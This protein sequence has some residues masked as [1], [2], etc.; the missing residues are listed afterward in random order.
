M[1]KTLWILAVSGAIFASCQKD[2]VDL[3]TAEGEVLV[4]FNTTLP[5]GLTTR[6]GDT[7]KGGVAENVDFASYD[8]RFIMEVYQPDGT[9]V[10]RVVNAVDAPSAANLE[11]RLAPGDYRFVFWADIV[12]QS[13][14][15]D[16]Y[17]YN[18]ASLKAVSLN[19]ASDFVAN[20]D[21][22]DAYTEYADVNLAG[23]FQQS[24]TL[25]RPFG[26]VRIVAKD[27][28]LAPAGATGRIVYSASTALPNGF[29]A[30]EKQTISSAALPAYAAAAFNDQADPSATTTTLAWDY[31]F[32]ADNAAY[33]FSFVALDGA[34]PIKTSVFTAVPVQKNKLTTISGNFFSYSAKFNVVV[35]EDFG[36]NIDVDGETITV[37]QLQAQLDAI[38]ASATWTGPVIL[39]ISDAVASAIGEIVIPDYDPAR[40]P[41]VMLVFESGITAAGSIDFIQ[42]TYPGIVRFVLP[43]NAGSLGVDLPIAQTI[44]EGPL[45]TFRPNLNISDDSSVT[46]AVGTFADLRTALHDNYDQY[47]NVPYN[48]GVLLTADITNANQDGTYWEQSVPVGKYMLPLDAAQLAGFVFDGGGH[49]LSGACSKNLLHVYADGVT[50]KNL[51]LSNSLGNGISFWDADG[52]NIDNVTVSNC[53]K[54]G[55]MLNSSTATIANSTTVGNTWGGVNVSIKSGMPT[56]HL[57]LGAG[58]NFQAFRP[59]W[60]DG[61]P[62]TFTPAPITDVDNHAAESWVTTAAGVPE[63]KITGIEFRPTIP[64]GNAQVVWSGHYQ[65]IWGQDPAAFI[66]ADQLYWRED[67]TTPKT[68]FVGAD[69]VTLTA[70]ANDAAWQTGYDPNDPYFRMSGLNFRTLGKY[71]L[72]T[73]DLKANWTAKS[74]L[75]VDNTVSTK[76]MMLYVVDEA[77]KAGAFV[78][79]LAYVTI[80]FANTGTD[81]YWQTNGAIRL[82]AADHLT[83]PGEYNVEFVCNG[84]T[85]DLKINGITAYT[86]TIAPSTGVSFPV[87]VAFYASMTSQEYV[88]K[89]SFPVVQ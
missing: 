66:T 31:I 52:V 47:V 13:A 57:T 69:Y 62:N 20:D 39:N 41:S 27:L 46:W 30:F 34:T 84:T 58:N 71:T 14:N 17:H 48:K 45:S 59:V 72:E 75:V 25:Y 73:S 16:D 67:R 40:I 68:W 88:S 35:E 63:W 43:S 18:T 42:G 9:F 78:N 82:T 80:A 26:K 29:N 79:P 8:L 32:A 51:R 23:N 77:T 55:I 2:S 15:T 49:V 10:K 87:M 64:A 4:S 12:P 21:T 44:I 3:A 56:P 36:D 38:A 74:K 65:Y 19:T 11:T 33:D 24:V 37:A 5:G 83:D 54:G 70:R 50:V 89:W 28:D 61:V 53:P 81:K 7:G 6:A 1:K 22:R 85:I 60:A 86:K 76:S